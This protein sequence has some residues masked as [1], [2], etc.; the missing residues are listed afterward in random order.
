MSIT[1][2]SEGKTDLKVEAIMGGFRHASRLL[3]RLLGTRMPG[4]L[5]LTGRWFLLYGIRNKDGGLTSGSIHSW[6][7]KEGTPVVLI[8]LSPTYPL[9]PLPPRTKVTWP[10]D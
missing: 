9:S 5:T 4:N 1:L 10:V 3:G 2:F 8:I 6:K 7:E